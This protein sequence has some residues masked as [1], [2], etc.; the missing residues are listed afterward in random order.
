M[1]L[2]IEQQGNVNLVFANMGKAIEAFERTIMVPAT[3]F[4]DYAAALEAKDMVSAKNIFYR[5]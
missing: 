2:T 3:R 1:K 5:H 4:D